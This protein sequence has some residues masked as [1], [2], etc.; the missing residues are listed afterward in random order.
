MTFVGFPSAAFDFYD[1]LEIDNSKT[2]WDAHKSV[3]EQ[4]VKQ[5]MLDLTS[6]LEPEFG[7][8]KLFRPYRDVRFARDKTP[9]KTHQGAF[10]AAGPATGWY[11]ELAASGFRVGAGY[12][13][14]SSARLA[15]IRQAIDAP[16]GAELEKLVRRLGRAGWQISGDAVKTTPRGYD[17]DHPRLELLRHKTLF[18]GRSYSF[19]EVIDRPD[20]VDRVRKDWRAVRPLVDW[21]ITHPAEV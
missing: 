16:T 19:D 21:L 8:A 17:A 3:Y 13:D 4:A 20:L 14:A 2:F 5:P 11:L 7:Q 18:A 1:D 12:Y 10:V 15:A 6:A 9:Y